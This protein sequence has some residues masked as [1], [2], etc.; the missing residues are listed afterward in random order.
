LLVQGAIALALVLVGTL[1][2][3]G[4]ATMVEYTAPVF[5]FFFFMVGLSLILLRLKDPH[6]KRPFRAPL[7]PLLPVVFCAS[8]LY[9]LQASI[10]YTGI[11]ALV[12]VAVLL[13]G[14]PVFLVARF[15][16]PPASESEENENEINTSP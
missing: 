10:A 14:L 1:T 7:H 12:G 4:F 9:M 6:I 13:A 16:Q 3:R 8:C 5:W 15:S 2:R 11:G